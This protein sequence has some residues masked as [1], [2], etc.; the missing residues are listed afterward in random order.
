MSIV[1]ELR[2]GTKRFGRVIL[3]FRRGRASR[4]GLAASL[5]PLLVGAVLTGCALSACGSKERDGVDKRTH[6]GH[7]RSDGGSDTSSEGKSS[8]TVTVAPDAASTG[9]T[10]SESTSSGENSSGEGLPDA[11]T[12]GSLDLAQLRF[13]K[14]AA[15]RGHW[16][17]ITEPEQSLVCVEDT[18]RVELPGPIID[19]DMSHDLVEFHHWCAVTGEG[20]VVCGDEE[21]EFAGTAEHV[22]VG[23]FNACASDSAH[24]ECFFSSANGG[25]DSPPSGGGPISAEMSSLCFAARDFHASCFNPQGDELLPREGHYLDVVAVPGGVCA[26]IM[27]SPA[28]VLMPDAGALSAALGSSGVVCF[29]QSG[30]EVTPLSGTY[31]QLDADVNGDG[32]AFGGDE[33][34]TQQVRCWGAHADTVPLGIEMP[35]QIAVSMTQ[36]C[37][38]DQQGRVTCYQKQ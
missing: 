38:L 1:N 26:A 27:A 4:P 7:E 2:G 25:F 22:S 17:G 37:I 23:F 31:S 28:D 21:M 13:S 14:I 30:V 36:V 33:G 20:R 16:C 35:K 11:A 19:F 5:E 8:Q 32:C 29:Q 34:E 9:E 10:A 6:G 18:P 12:E 3:A 15:G 24:V